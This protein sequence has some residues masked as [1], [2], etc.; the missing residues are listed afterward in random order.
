MKQ[1]VNSGFTIIALKSVPAVENII[2][3]QYAFNAL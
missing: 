1:F 2:D 3:E